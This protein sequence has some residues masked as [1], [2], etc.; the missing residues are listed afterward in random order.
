[1]SDTS[2]GAQSWWIDDRRITVLELYGIVTV[3]RPDGS[4][5]NDGAAFWFGVCLVDREADVEVYEDAPIEAIQSYTRFQCFVAREFGLWYRHPPAEDVT[6]GQAAWS[7]CV[8]E[9][10]GRRRPSADVE[11]GDYFDAAPWEADEEA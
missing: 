8:A 4:R 11:H 2:L 3:R 7:E 9:A 10:W 6:N 5:W 1:M